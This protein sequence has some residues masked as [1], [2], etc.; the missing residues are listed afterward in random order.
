MYKRV[1][2]CHIYRVGEMERKRDRER[3]REGGRE[4]GIEEERYKERR[5]QT[6][7]KK[8]RFYSRDTEIGRE[9]LTDCVCVRERE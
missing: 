4:G 8:I 3:E 7:R 5:G 1:S 9:R 6:E 2:R